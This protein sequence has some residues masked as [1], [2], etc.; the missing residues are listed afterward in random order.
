MEFLAAGQVLPQ[1]AAFPYPLI[2]T[3]GTGAMHDLARARAGDSGTPVIVG[4]ALDL[5]QIAERQLDRRRSPAQIL[6]TASGY[7]HPDAL[8]SFHAAK[9]RENLTELR[10]AGFPED[11]LRGDASSQAAKGDGPWPDHPL[12][13]WDQPRCLRDG[14]TGRPTAELFI[15]LLPTDDPIEAPAFLDDEGGDE[16]PPPEYLVV[17]LRSWWQRF[18]AVPVVI[19]RDSLELSVA[20]PLQ[21]RDTA[22]A[23]AREFYEICPD[24]VGQGAGSVAALAATL[25]D[26]PFW[27]LWWD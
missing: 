2:R 24:S 21:D 5:Q 3:D 19:T 14:L 1:A 16:R 15:A 26:S 18:G 25:L 12:P 10:A 20:R 27:Y 8:R 13:G 23:L 7:S 6:A 11:L 17:A 9:H 22:L 4:Q